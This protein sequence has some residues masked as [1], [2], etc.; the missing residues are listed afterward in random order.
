MLFCATGCV[1]GHEALKNE[2]YIVIKVYKLAI[3]EILGEFC[4]SI[5]CMS[6][7]SLHIESDSVIHL[8]CTVHFAVF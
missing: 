2:W 7:L 1:I 8:A 5:Y 3:F 4:I 6:A